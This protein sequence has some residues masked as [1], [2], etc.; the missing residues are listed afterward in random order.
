[1]CQRDLAAGFLFSR[2]PDFFEPFANSLFE[3]SREGLI[4]TGSGE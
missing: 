4:E 2:F 3:A 1:M